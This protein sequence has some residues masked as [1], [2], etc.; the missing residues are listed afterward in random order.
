[1]KELKRLTDVFSE[2][3]H[4]INAV[5]QALQMIADAKRVFFIG[6]GGSAAIA[7]HMAA[8]WL[9][10]GGVAAMTFNDPPL[11]SAI[12]NDVGYDNSF[13]IPLSLHGG[14]G[15]L[16]VAISSSGESKNII[17]AADHAISF[18]MGLITL[19]GFRQNN[20][21]RGRGQVNFYVNSMEYGLVEV[22]HHAILHALMDTY[23]RRNH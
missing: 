13:V 5:T 22:A 9:K 11:M 14:K 2:V 3:D 7:S 4:E 23:L 8:D 21:L 10:N 18:Q 12:A 20:S 17:R 15:D 6:N 16:L 19:S 1:M